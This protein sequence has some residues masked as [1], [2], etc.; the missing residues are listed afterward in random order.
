MLFNLTSTI[1]E[2]KNIV[3]YILFHE[4]ALHKLQTYSLK[5]RKSEKSD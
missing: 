5:A 2:K 4:R 3:D 1:C